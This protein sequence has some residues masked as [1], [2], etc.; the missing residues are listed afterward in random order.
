MTSGL[1]VGVTTPHV[2]IEERNTYHLILIIFLSFHIKQV[3]CACVGCRGTDAPP[4]LLE[5]AE[6]LQYFLRDYNA[7]VYSSLCDHEIILSGL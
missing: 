4:T 7:F 6:R 5:T 3:N 2:N 1:I